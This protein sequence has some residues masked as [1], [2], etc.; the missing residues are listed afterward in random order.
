MSN[1]RSPI[2]LVLPGR[3]SEFSLA[4]C[5]GK[6]TLVLL[7]SVQSAKENQWFIDAAKQWAL[8]NLARAEH[9]NMVVIVDL[10]GI[11]QM[12]QMVAKETAAAMVPA[13]GI[14]AL[15]FDAT[16]ATRKAFGVKESGAPLVAL[17]SASGVPVW[18]KFGK[19]PMDSIDGLKAKLIELTDPLLSA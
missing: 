13:A 8:D 12:F 4:E 19:L 11:P 3:T 1:E 15:A 2:D 10:S 9:L 7:Q 16:D 5:R 18:G 14:S 17:L 6:P